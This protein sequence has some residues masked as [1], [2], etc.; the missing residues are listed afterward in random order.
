MHNKQ[1]PQ[2][3]SVIN[4]KKLFPPMVNVLYL[5]NEIEKKIAMLL[6]GQGKKGSDKQNIEKIENEMKDNIT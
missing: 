3:L 2:Q 6:G 4:Q 1:G 5:E